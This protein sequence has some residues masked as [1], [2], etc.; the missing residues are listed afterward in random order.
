MKILLATDDSKFSEAAA[1]S[2]AGQFRPQDTEV[3]VLQVVEPIA[4]SEPPQMSSGY[5]PELESQLSQAREAVD[6]V[7]KMLSSAGF[8]VTTSV[9]T[10]DARS[11]I[12]EDAAKWHADL[13]VLGS[14]GRKGLGRF[15]LGSVSEAV[16]RH[17]HCSVQIVRVPS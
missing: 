2:L 4:I 7:A 3:R 11:V 12:L 8:R 9:A 15:F 5:Y 17:A 1:K 16:A 14:H 6:R 13:I 10:G